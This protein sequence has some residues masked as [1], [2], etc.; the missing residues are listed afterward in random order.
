MEVIH[1]L[2]NMSAEQILRFMNTHWRDP[3]TVPADVARSAIQVRVADLLCNSID[4]ARKDFI[5]MLGDLRRSID[6]F[7]KSN[8]RTSR[9]IVLLTIVLAATAVVQ[10]VLAILK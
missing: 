4:G 6:E 1:H 9:S 2:E 7:R 8:E 10:V 5:P 3:D